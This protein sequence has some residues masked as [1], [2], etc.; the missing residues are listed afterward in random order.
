MDAWLPDQ[1]THLRQYALEYCGQCVARV[2]CAIENEP[3]RSVI[4]GAHPS[5]TSVEERNAHLERFQE[6]PR[7]VA[8]Q[9]EQQTEI[10]FKQRS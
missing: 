7:Q 5:V 1:R 3:D 10:A 8:D 4:N 2:A 6:S 9:L